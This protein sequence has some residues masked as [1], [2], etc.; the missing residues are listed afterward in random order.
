LRI[1]E[2]VIDGFNLMYKF[3]DSE[4]LIYENKIEDAKKSLLNHLLFFYQNSKNISISLYLDGRNLENL[5]LTE[6]SWNEIYIHYSHIRKAD[7]FIKAHIRKSLYHSRI[8]LVSSDKELIHYAK[9]YGCK[10]LKS[11]EFFNFYN[12]LIKK[13]EV[14]EEKEFNINLTNG[15]VNMWLQLFRESNNV[16]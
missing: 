15:E 16:N 10:Y 2:Y 11:E 3:P 5:S 13:R 14:L 4:S 1:E 8:T 6:E 9:K 12:E 7:Y